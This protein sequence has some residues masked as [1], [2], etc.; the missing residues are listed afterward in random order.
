M[1]KRTTLF[2]LLFL[3]AITG[4]SLFFVL[5][6]SNM[7]L[8]EESLWGSKEETLYPTR[9]M[10]SGVQKDIWVSAQNGRLHHLIKSPRSVLTAIPKGKNFELVEEMLGMKCYLQENLENGHQQI[11]FIESHSGTYYYLDQRFIARQVFLALFRLPG[12]ELK[13]ELDY[14]AAFLKGV[15]EEVSLSFSQ[16]SPN[17]HAEKFKA[18]IRPEKREIYE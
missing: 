14:S 3:M 12:Q 15:A 4:L 17:F 11:R 1:L 8:T 6:P 18:H 10:R 2:S 13:T 16:D 7:P 9:Q 5:A